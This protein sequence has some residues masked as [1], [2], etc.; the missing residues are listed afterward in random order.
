MICSK[1]SLLTTS[2]LQ[3]HKRRSQPQQQLQ[4]RLHQLQLQLNQ[5]NQLRKRPPQ[6]AKQ[7]S[8]KSSR[9]PH[10]L[11][12]SQLNLPKRKTKNHNSNTHQPFWNWLNKAVTKNSAQP[13]NLNPTQLKYHKKWAQQF[14]P[15]FHFKREKNT[16]NFI[17]FPTIS[18]MRSTKWKNLRIN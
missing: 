8:R 10:Q 4:L 17:Y 2:Q 3:V 13:K 1:P 7:P 6:N 15:S 5:P 14:W 11:H 16:I 18:R 12:Q 9:R